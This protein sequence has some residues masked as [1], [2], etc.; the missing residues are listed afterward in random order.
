MCIVHATCNVQKQQSGKYNQTHAPSSFSTYIRAI[1]GT[2]QQLRALAKMVSIHSL[3]IGILIL[4]SN[5]I[6]NANAFIL[7]K[8]T[9][10]QIQSTAFISAKKSLLNEHARLHVPSQLTAS[11]F[12]D[13]DDFEASSSSSSSESSSN[14]DASIY[15]SL[16]ARQ[17]SL[18]S[19]P[20]L[21][22][23]ESTDSSSSEPIF[24]Y[25]DED[26]LASNWKGGECVSSV[27]L[28]LND[29]IRRI[30]I[31]TYPLA[32]CGSAKGNIYLVDLE[33][34]EELDCVTSVHEAQIDDEE[35]TEAM[36][37]LYGKYDGGGVIAIAIHN[38]IV[39]SAGREGGL[40]VFKIDG[41]EESYYKGSRGASASST[42][43]HLKSEGKIWYLD[44]T[45]VT[46]LAFDDVGMLWTGGYDGFVRAFEYDDSETPLEMQK[47][48][49][50]ELDV[51]SEVLSVSI[52]NEIGCGVAATAGG[53]VALFSLEEGEIM[54]EWKP[55]G[56]GVGKRKREYARC[57]TI[58]QNDQE[59]VTDDG[60]KQA[61]IW[62]VICGG[63]E[64][65]LYQKR[66]NID[67]L[68]YVSESKPFLNDDSL[69]GRLRPSHRDIV[70]ALSSPSPGLILTGS[71]DSTIR[72]WNC[73]YYRNEESGSTI[74]HDDD[75]EEEAYYDDIG[76]LDKRPKC[77]YALTGYKA[78]LG[79][80][81][82][83]GKILIT[84]GSDN[85]IV[86]HDFSG[87]DDNSEG[88]MFEDD[89][90][91]DFSL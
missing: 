77:L 43:L 82:T 6:E 87:E 1:I 89:D 35:V 69:R 10:P 18:S 51:G 72:V 13:F 31:D 50:Y 37:K 63:S 5:S 78:W 45:L 49:M 3:A 2:I 42:K 28:Q 24:E 20:F 9:K 68:A 55:F 75:D 71:Q 32:V 23:T 36:K 91:E 81:F 26:E 17:D 4:S 61:A 59:S 66:L 33:N 85:T 15:A 56:R 80:M 16:R 8:H 53:T 79:S 34:A 48:P 58:V 67:S 84:D 64:G 11:L 25:N 65:S 74:I 7:A 22:P 70:M 54:A 60:E 38:D 41:E 90:L 52:N 88:F 27:R 14:Q 46:D 86:S 62:S 76:V 83:N 73:S 29:W 21:H 19:S 39:V 44:S 57:A 12:D 40:H 47:E 30:A